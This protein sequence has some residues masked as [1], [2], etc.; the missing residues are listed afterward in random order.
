MNKSPPKK[1]ADPHHEYCCPVRFRSS[2]RS[3]IAAAEMAVLSRPESVAHTKS[4]AR[5]VSHVCDTWSVATHNRNQSP[6]DLLDHSLFFLLGVVVSVKL[7][8]M[9]G[10]ELSCDVDILCASCLYRL[11]CV[12]SRQVNRRDLVC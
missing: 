8:A 7:V 3:Y 5:V 4:F 11:D 2:L 1:G 9:F 12:L 6:V 10:N